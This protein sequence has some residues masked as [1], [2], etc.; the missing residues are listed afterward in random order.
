MPVQTADTLLIESAITDSVVADSLQGEG[1]YGLVMSRVE[2]PRRG[3]GER[4]DAT[5]VSSWMFLGL[6]VLFC[7]SCFKFRKNTKFFR[8]LFHEAIIFR[9]RE[10]MLD[11]TVRE[12]TFMGLMEMLCVTGEGIV[13]WRLLMLT[14]SLSSSATGIWGCAVCIVAASVYSIFMAGAY[15]FT[16]RVF[17]TGITEMSLLRGFRAG[18][19]LTG[20]TIFLP[21]VLL[22]FSGVEDTWLVWTGVGVFGLWKILFLYRSLRIFIQQNSVWLV[23][24][25]Y[26]CSVEIIPVI[27]MYSIAEK[28]CGL[29]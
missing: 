13:L 2:T 17:F 16:G 23:F 9:E 28:M 4:T 1:S 22:L 10:N 27:M 12:R 20:V 3:G 18:M 15:Y 8:Y 11:G 21:A 14:G 26:L 7:I 24:L 25:C 5:E 29:L 6:A 19:A